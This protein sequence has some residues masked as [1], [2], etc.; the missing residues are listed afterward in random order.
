MLGRVRVRIIG[1]HTDSKG[2]LPTYDL[3]WS[4]CLNNTPSVSGVGQTGCNFLAGSWVLCMAM[5]DSWQ[6]TVVMGSLL[7]IPQSQE[8]SYDTSGDS[9]E[10]MAYKANEDETYIP[11][12]P[13]GSDGKEIVST[14]QGGNAI[15]PGSDGVGQAVGPLSASEYIL[16]RER[17][18]QKESGYGKRIPGGYTVGPS[19]KNGFVGRYQFGTRALK[20]MKYMHNCG[21]GNGNM[22]HPEHWTGLMNVVSLDTWK[23]TPAAQD[24]AMLRFAQSHFTSFR[25]AGVLRNDSDKAHT[26][27][28]LYT[29]HLLGATGAIRWAKRGIMGRDANKFTAKQAYDW[30]YPALT[31]K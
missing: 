16:W 8:G 4:I 10:P 7:G 17:V 27:G 11:N 14:E 21:N 2:V 6:T 26:C 9:I 22:H 3:P 24:D 23:S 1:I 25:N 5:D 19:A 18:A 15:I 29:A 30:A 20:D 12:A 13:T 31:Y 28:L